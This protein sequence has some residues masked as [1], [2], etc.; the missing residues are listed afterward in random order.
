LEKLRD[1]IDPLDG[2]G[3][4][5]KLKILELAGGKA[6]LL[7]FREKASKEAKISAK[8]KRCARLGRGRPS[9]SSKK[10][11]P[12]EV[13][14]DNLSEHRVETDKEVQSLISE[15]ARNRTK[16]KTN[17]NA[18]SSR[19][20]LIMTVR[21]VI[22]K[23]SGT[24]IKSKINFADLAG[25]EKVGKTNVKGD[26]LKEAT[27]IN[28]S[29]TALRTVID[30]LVKQ[31]K[32]I[33]FRNSKLTRAL[34][35]SLGGNT[36]TTL[37][38]A[39]SPHK[40]NLE[41]TIETLKFGRRAKFIRS[42][43]IIN[44][45]ASVEQLQQ[46]ISKLK[47][48]NELLKQ[49]L[50]IEHAKQ[51][52]RRLE[53]EGPRRELETSMSISMLSP[54]RNKGI[55][56]LCREKERF[57]SISPMYQAKN[58]LNSDHKIGSIPLLSI[59]RVSTTDM[60]DKTLKEMQVPSTHKEFGHQESNSK[61]KELEFELDKARERELKFTNIVEE[62]MERLDILEHEKEVH[63]E[64]Q[65]IECQ[66]E[67]RS[68]Y[69]GQLGS[70]QNEMTDPQP[71]ECSL[72]Q[73]NIERHPVS[74]LSTLQ[75]QSGSIQKTTGIIVNEYS[76]QSWDKTNNVNEISFLND[77]TDQKL[78]IDFVHKTK[79]HEEN[80]ADEVS[81]KLQKVKNDNMKLSTPHNGDID[82]VLMV[83]ETIATI[84]NK[85][86]LITLNRLMEFFQLAQLSLQTCMHVYTFFPEGKLTV[87]DIVEVVQ[88]AKLSLRLRERAA[89]FKK[90]LIG[91]TEDFAEIIQDLPSVESVLPGEG[92]SNLT[93]EDILLVELGEVQSLI[94]QEGFRFLHSDESD[95]VLLIDFT[96]FIEHLVG[97]GEILGLS[98]GPISLENVEYSGFR[99][100]LLEPITK[101]F[102]NNNYL[103]RD[104]TN[105]LSSLGSQIV[106]Q[107]IRESLEDIEADDP[108]LI[109]LQD[110]T[111]P[112]LEVVVRSCPTPM[113]H[114]L[115]EKQDYY[116]NPDQCS[117]FAWQS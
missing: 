21:L 68:E 86:M 44:A 104:G 67:T 39:C 91:V 85:S 36:K 2:N 61:V 103:S 5:K 58:S 20:H 4:E 74:G 87:N 3:R 80:I 102:E 75:E 55:L 56:G 13:I 107:E 28:T 17:L 23:N 59:H 99:T 83:L 57:N 65:K 10:E 62:L 92:A 78:E 89:A 47:A 72:E 33:S 1:L 115:V 48:Q 101:I 64:L 42:E 54:G 26:R 22:T 112:N 77:H 12:V 96:I 81:D 52:I 94:F 40:W 100:E 43:V 113:W 31:K 110:L 7:A 88:A 84:E 8:N 98:Q 34:R 60:N 18:S 76:V 30:G 111:L 46:E 93:M 35:D 50:C 49:K 95:E 32:Y 37:V 24:V 11:L 45:Q 9:N 29:L 66:E 38:L 117:Y 106:L 6:A 90:Q 109:I 116:T 82:S 16:E 108:G 15:A 73:G 70:F 69:N 25:S 14:I 97:R 41:E 114:A 105:N 27:A 53:I 51:G 19:S 79:V 63:N 71:V